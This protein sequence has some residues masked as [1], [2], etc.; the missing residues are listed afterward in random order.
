M[1]A[2]VTHFLYIAISLSI[3]VWVGRTLFKNGHIFL[4]DAF[5]GSETKANAVNNLLIIGFYLVNLGLISLLLRKGAHPTNAVE[6]IELLSAKIGTVLL[7]LGALHY[8]NVLNIA[9]MSRKAK[10]RAATFDKASA[11]AASAMI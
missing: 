3:T 8:F 11:E 1:Y 2:L 7:V 6:V 5:R 9:K 10:K 4:I